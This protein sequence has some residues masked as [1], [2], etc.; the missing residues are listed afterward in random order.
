MCECFIVKP[1]LPVI[2]QTVPSHEHSEVLRLGISI[3]GMCHSSWFKALN[4]GLHAKSVFPIYQPPW[5]RAPRPV[6]NEPVLRLGVSVFEPQHLAA[7]ALDKA[8]WLWH[9]T[10]Q[11]CMSSLWN[12]I[13]SSESSVWGLSFFSSPLVFALQTTSSCYLRDHDRRAGAPHSDMV[14]WQHQDHGRRE[15][16]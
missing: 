9:S 11:L 15:R 13:V 4:D 2:C 10:P 14:T 6:A 8:E 5:L 7:L 16:L 3:T 12:S 1:A